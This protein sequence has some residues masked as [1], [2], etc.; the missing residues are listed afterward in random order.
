[1]SI[2]KSISKFKIYSNLHHLFIGAFLLFFVLQVCFWFKTEKLKPDA[3]IV[4]KLPS[5]E[6]V[7]AFSLGDPQ[8]YFRLNA[9]RIE[10]A[11]DTFGRFTA[12]KKYNYSDLYKWFKLLDN[13]DHKSKYVPSLAANYYSQTQTPE[14]TRYIVKY[15]DEYASVNI[16]EDWWWMFQAFIIANS[17]LKDKDLALTL[18]KKLGENENENAPIWTR[19]L[20][21]LAAAKLG[22]DCEAFSIISRIMEDDENG[23]K[24]IAPKEMAFMRHF[25]KQRLDNLKKKN[26]NPRA[27]Y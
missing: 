6:S 5:K 27:C 25:I 24:K 16:D 12:L 2:F 8:F 3:Q 11:G 9:L 4:P 13:L 15:L 14:D 23:T 7:A 18:A 22:K 17:T 20:A 26:F 21:G 1:M 19:Q 10:N